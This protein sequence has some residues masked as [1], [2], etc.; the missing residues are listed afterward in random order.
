MRKDKFVTNFFRFFGVACTLL[1]L[2]KSMY[3]KK[4]MH[5]EIELIIIV[6]ILLSLAFLFGVNFG[7]SLKSTD[8]KKSLDD[9]P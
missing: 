4:F 7:F 6:L 3:D 9:D 1:L 2:T 8:T 5:V